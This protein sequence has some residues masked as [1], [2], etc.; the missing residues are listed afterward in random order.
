MDMQMRRLTGLQRKK[1]DEEYD[2]L[3][4]AINDFRDILANHHRV[5]NII[6]VKEEA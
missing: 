2:Q 5:L 1:I 3:V 6:T 4:V